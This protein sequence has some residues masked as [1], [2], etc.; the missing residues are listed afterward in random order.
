MKLKR[1][2]SEPITGKPVFAEA[3][4]SDKDGKEIG[5]RMIVYAES[6][7]DE[8]LIKSF[9]IIGKSKPVTVHIKILKQWSVTSVY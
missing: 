8:Y 5:K 2:L 4:L 1:I 6:D 9:G 7:S 3:T